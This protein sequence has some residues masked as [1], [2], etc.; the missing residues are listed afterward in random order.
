MRVCERDNNNNCACAHRPVICSPPA[1]PVARRHGYNLHMLSPSRPTDRLSQ[2]FFSTSERRGP[3]ALCEPPRW[4]QSAV[5]LCLLCPWKINSSVQYLLTGC[6]AASNH[7]TTR[8]LAFCSAASWLLPNTQMELMEMETD[9]ADGG[10]R[11]HGWR[12]PV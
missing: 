8:H 12:I 7:N 6:S 3:S 11:T 1:A 5:L 10:H 9:G 4:R 2:H